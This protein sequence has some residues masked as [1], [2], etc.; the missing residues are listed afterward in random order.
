MFKDIDNVGIVNDLITSIPNKSFTVKEQI[1]FESENI[2]YVSY[3][4]DKVSD[5][6]WAVVFVKTYKDETKPYL[7]LHNIK[8][9][10][11]KN[12]KIK[13]G[14]RFI[15]NPFEL[16][17][18]LKID[19]FEKQFKTKQI[20]GKWVKTDEEEDILENWMVVQK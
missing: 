1:Q 5:K 4:N 6:F 15:E 3:T 7:T 11:K 10:E 12:T 20:G 8:T 17:S 9:G 19:S 2:Q 18:I 13:K 16:Y 14:N